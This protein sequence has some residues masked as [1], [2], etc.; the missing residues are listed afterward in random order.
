MS[1]V[2]LKSLA[3]SSFWQAFNALPK[4]IQEVARKGF[5]LWQRNPSHPSLHFKRVGQYWSVRV[6]ISY[7]ALALKRGDD[8]VW[9]WIGDHDDYEQLIK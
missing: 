9:F 2:S 1:P 5:K 7:R 6:G 8:F 3:A 4:E